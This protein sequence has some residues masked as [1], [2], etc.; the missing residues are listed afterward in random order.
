MDKITDII[1][2][3]VSEAKVGNREKLDALQRLR[4]FVPDDIEN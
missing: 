1:E 4:R 2:Q 3:G